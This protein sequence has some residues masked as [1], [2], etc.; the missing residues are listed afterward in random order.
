[1]KYG[2][3]LQVAHLLAGVALFSSKLAEG[4]W[5]RCEV[6]QSKVVI[7]AYGF[8]TLSS[9]GNMFAQCSFLIKKN[10]AI[11]QIRLDFSNFKYMSA[12]ATGNCEEDKLTIS[13]SATVKDGF[14][15]C[16]DL[17]G[18][19]MYLTFGEDCDTIEVTTKMSPISPSSSYNI[20]MTPI[21]CSSPGL[22]P[23]HCLQHF[24]GSQG[25]VRSFDYPNQQQNS[26]EYTVCVEPKGGGGE[27]IIWKSCGSEDGYPSSSP[28][29]ITTNPVPPKICDTDWVAINGD[30]PRCD[31]FPTSV[32]STWKPFLLNVNFNE[33]EIPPP[34][35]GENLGD[36]DDVYSC[37]GVGVASGGLLMC[38]WF[39]ETGPGVEGTCQ[40]DINPIFFSPGIDVNVF[41]GPPP[42]MGNTGF[43][44]KYDMQ[45]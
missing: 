30:V 40:C 37:I 11:C 31:K 41:F 15:T 42:D 32:R 25:V 45:I 38:A 7:D 17:T 39:P 22:V 20:L 1:M 8:R 35:F 2:I 3:A 4:Q 44:L 29:S 13:N 9:P 19:H 33:E 18:Q 23:S 14:T 27:E 10:P 6:G 36:V 16:G 21:P 28:F 34:R 5:T 24:N 12:N 26:Q 43:C